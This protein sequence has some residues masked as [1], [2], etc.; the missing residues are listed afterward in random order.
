[1]LHEIENIGDF[2]DAFDVLE[3]RESSAFITE[4]VKREPAESEL[5]YPTDCD[6]PNDDEN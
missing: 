4:P 2:M 1:M 5:I 6:E 3:S